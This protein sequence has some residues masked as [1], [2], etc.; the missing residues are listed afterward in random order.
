MWKAMHEIMVYNCCH[1]EFSYYHLSRYYHE[2]DQ[3]DLLTSQ[4]QTTKQVV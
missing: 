4:G 2:I 1:K 3:S